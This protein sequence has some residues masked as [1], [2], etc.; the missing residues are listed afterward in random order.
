MAKVKSFFIKAG[1]WFKNHVPTKRRLIQIYSALL[2]NAN[3]KGYIS[4]TI[5]QGN[6]KKLCMPGLNCYSCPGAVTACPLGALQDSLSQTGQRAPYYI[7]GILGLFG[8]ILARTICGFLCPMGLGQDLLYHI[9]SPK[10][11]KSR[12][13]RILAY[14]KYVLLAVLVIAIPIIY[15]GVPA[16][17]KYV[18]PAG[19]FGGAIGLLA[20]PNNDSFY[21]MLGYLFSWKFALLI[22]FIVASIFIYR[23]FCRFF[24]PL[25]A[26]LGFF[27]KIALIGVKLDKNKCIDCGACL[28]ECKMDIKH[29]G[30]HEC[31]NCGKCIPVCPTKAISWKGGKIILEPTALFKPQKEES[32]PK[33]SAV[34]AAG[35]VSGVAQSVAAD[36]T[37]IKIAA[38]TLNN[39]ENYQKQAIENAEENDNLPSEEKSV[40]TKEQKLKKRSFWLQFSAWAV[41]LA[42]LLSALIFYNLPS[43]KAPLTVYGLGDRCPD[44]TLETIYDTA[45]AFGEDGKKTEKFSTLESKGKVMVFNFWYT[46][47]DPCKEE[48]PSFNSISKE[49]GEDVVFVV[50]HIVN[51]TSPE[52]VQA[53]IDSEGF[54]D[55]SMLFAQDTE[56]IDS[57]RMLGGNAS[58]PR[59]VI[60]NTG[61]KISYERLGKIG[62]KELR[63]AITEALN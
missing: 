26:I 31:I 4:G 15:Q 22:V 37:E 17:C 9:K 43:N 48:L 60:V 62:E 16:F 23:F 14:F 58:C 8:L 21:D 49:F 5:Y 24:C 33:L 2:F 20:N 42:V 25:G 61:Y 50:I 47:C 59:T 55:F 52:D 57:F 29:V 56:E 27:N 3:L 39:Q 7:L 38:E 40:L 6:T 19:T 35:S 1:V 10:V 36:K 53:T 11:K 12:Y 54:S 34:L 32:A 44:F 46:T 18:C 30:D 41:A 63:T 28:Q 51:G 45:G 13:T